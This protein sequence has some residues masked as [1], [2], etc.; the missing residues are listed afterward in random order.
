MTWAGIRWHPRNKYLHDYNVISNYILIALCQSF[1]IC[2]KGIKISAPLVVVTI[3]DG[4]GLSSQ[5]TIS[6]SCI[7]QSL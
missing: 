6:G 1:L 3:K 7:H 4:V 5:E 2:I